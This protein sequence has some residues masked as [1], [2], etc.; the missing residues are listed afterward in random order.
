M[1]R[2]IHFTVGDDI[3][4]AP[5]FV[6]ADTGPVS[7][8]EDTQELPAVPPPGATESTNAMTRQDA[9]SLAEPTGVLA[10]IAAPP[11]ETTEPPVALPLPRQLDNLAPASGAG[12][13]ALPVPVPGPA[14]GELLSVPV[15][16]VAL[17]ARA[18]GGRRLVPEGTIGRYTA[19]YRSGPEAG[20]QLRTVLADR[21]DRYASLVGAIADRLPRSVALEHDDA[22]FADLV[23]VVA[24]AA[25]DS[26]IDASVPDVMSCLVSGVL[27]LPRQPGP[28]FAS[29]YRASG[30]QWRPGQ[31]YAGAEALGAT[32]P[33]GGPAL[34]GPL[35]AVWS[36]TGR[37]LPGLAD[38]PGAVVFV[39]GTRFQVIGVDGRYPEQ[40]D[41]VLLRELLPQP[42]VPAASTPSD[43]RVRESLRRLADARRR[44][45][46]LAG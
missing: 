21:Y 45:P 6:D 23:A 7:M 5:N 19:E 3:W 22:A 31:V 14:A 1:D 12:P 24:L 36:V 25:G 18:P 27:R 32:A 20:A 41:L 33:P 11:G 4:P 13:V 28:M 9:V 44:A 35:M 34:T 37:R 16:T 30:S 40:P 46:D 42:A 38:G 26:A 2:G 39:P 17:P 8:F 10:E 43:Q 15:R 29:W